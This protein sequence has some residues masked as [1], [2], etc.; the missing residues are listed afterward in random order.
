MNFTRKPP[1]LAAC[2]VVLTLLW[3]QAAFALEAAPADFGEAAPVPV[4][5]V[6]LL[7]A[8]FA[9]SALAPD[10]G[11][12]APELPESVLDA[13]PAPPRVS[14]AERK[15]LDKV[16]EELGPVVAPQ[17]APALYAALETMFS[18]LGAAQQKLFPA[19]AISMNRVYVLDT[20]VV[21]A[22]VYA[23]KTPG[24]RR[25]NNLVFITTGML[26]KMLGDDQAGLKEGLVRTAG[27]LSHELAHPLDNIDAEGIKANYGQKVGSQAREIRADSEGTLIAKEAGYPIESVHEALKRLCGD[28]SGAKNSARAWVGTHPENGL[29]LAMQRML[30]T[31]NRHERGVRAPLYP[32]A[33]SPAILEE[34]SGIE[35]G[36]AA[37]RFVP[38]KDLAE[39]L[40][41]ME[42]LFNLKRNDAYKSLEFNR[43]ALATNALL[44][45]KGRLDDEDFARFT[46]INRFL[47]E[48]RQLKL[49]DRAG[50]KALFTKESHSEEFLAYPPHRVFMKKIPAYNDARYFDWARANLFVR[51]EGYGAMMTGLRAAADVLP[52]EHIFSLFGELMAAAMPEEMNY[53]PNA[54][55]IYDDHLSKGYSIEAQ[56]RMAV[57]FHEKV[58]PRMPEQERVEF[59]V[60]GQQEKY[61]YV[62]PQTRGITAADYGLGVTKDRARLFGDPRLQ[63]L[64]DD[65]RKVLRAIWDNRGYYAVL[66][67]AV[68][69]N[70]MDWDAVFSGLGIDPQAGRGQLRQAVKRFS[71]TGEYA[72]LVRTFQH[73]RVKA[74]HSGKLSALGW[75]DDTLGPYLAGR[76]NGALAADAELRILAAR[77]FSASYYQ[78]RPQA[79]ARAYER[80]LR[81]A[82]ARQDGKPMTLAELGAAHQAVL[83]Y[84][85]GDAARINVSL[86]AAQARAIDESGLPADN[87]RALLREIFLEGYPEARRTAGLTYDY[88]WVWAFRDDPDFKGVMKILIKDGAVPDATDFFA[89]LLK[90]KDFRRQ[91][92]SGYPG[93]ISEVKDELLG[94]L[95]AALAA[96]ATGPEKA[97]AI[98]RFLSVVADPGDGDYP[99]VQAFNTPELRGIKASAARAAEGL[100]APF[101]QRLEIFRRLTGTGATPATDAFFQKN[102]EPDFDAAAA[103]AAGLPLARILESARISGAAL[104][105]SLAR[106]LLDPEVERLGSGPH[107][108]ADLNRL[109]ETLNAY[110]RQGSFQKDEYLEDLAWRL[111]LSGKEL[112]VFIEDEKSYNWRKA[113]PLLLRLGS[114]LSAEIAKLSAPARAQFISFLIDPEGRELPGAILRE[115]QKNAYAAA[116]AA[117]AVENYHKPHARLRRE[118]DRSAYLT[119]LELEA[120]L[121][122]ASP[123][124]RIPIF[125]L[126]LSAGPAA[127]QNAAEFPHNVTRTFLGYAPGST[128]GKTL[129]AYLSVV[130]AHE[131][132]VSLAYLLSQAGQNKS[133]VKHIFEVFQ[134]VGVKFGQMSSTWKIFGEEIARQ[135]ASLKDSARPMTKAE[136]EA[137]MRRA[138]APGELSRVKALKRVIGSA[139][140]KTVVLVELADGREAVMLVRR[141]HAAEQIESNLDLGRAFLRELQGRGLGRASALLES[142]LDAVR[143]QL[144]EEILFTKEA[145]NLRDAKKYYEGLNAS[146]RAR[147]GG[148]RFHVPG[149]IEGFEVRDGILF[150]EKA[151]GTT[152]DKLSP[153]TQAQ[154]GPLLAD[155]SVTL[156]FRDGWFDADRHV[157]NQFIDPEKKI[158]YPIDF[159]Q[160][161]RYSKKSFWRRDDRYALAQFLR[162][163][164]EGDADGLIQSGQALAQPGS[165]P[166]NLSALRQDVRDILAGE[167]GPLDRMVALVSA[168]AERG[169]RLDGRFTFGALKGLMTL[170]G[171]NYVPEAGLRALLSRRVA[172]LLRSKFPIALRDAR[173]A[174]AG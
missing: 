72:A 79:F 98:E 108:A 138:R 16:E 28:E 128:E 142:A 168:F 117:D 118:S 150:M 6:G 88:A 44:A 157:G 105:L 11:V 69:F 54:R 130:P 86:S 132:T 174:S 15:T 139:S 143:L 99:A 68:P 1:R 59:F 30:L 74:G 53:Q 129:D 89:R 137:A 160:A 93:L 75:L 110:V 32:E 27:V 127:L 70:A 71:T 36:A 101:A 80:A 18:R 107:D 58:L 82:L 5:E 149:L 146:M 10:A 124:E 91:G 103:E 121:S 136:I 57:L 35:L 13:A 92:L 171:E 21:N 166:A 67:F 147:L 152:F 22:F 77:T 83:E 65:Y 173:A 169:A 12:A 29:R 172:A 141:P 114:A 3:A 2:G 25:S 96:S 119:K 55:Y 163:I 39:A 48:P 45:Q 156:L 159:G 135:T 42:N 144:A 104:Q 38:P 162:A 131:K 112:D 113:N 94:D 120:A 62:F 116:L 165:A 52:A 34:L 154:A 158:I 148:W 151:D 134:T 51:R 102:V 97:A 20:P 66:D 85:A 46:A 17:D 153:Q 63:S 133:S 115:L 26:K 37:S 50:M 60:N 76:F 145:Q 23:D 140:L 78:A 95:D 7:P 106:R 84:L 43:L 40:G 161:A 122:D 4:P 49:V 64:Q 170:Y 73:G 41:R 31:M 81:A 8:D 47:T 123:A 111:G 56:V 19:D 167:G 9:P 125:E 87:K 24:V 14:P 109:V 164:A 90:Q 61:S 100:A 155:A 126:L 33:A